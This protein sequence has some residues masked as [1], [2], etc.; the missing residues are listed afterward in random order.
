MYIMYIHAYVFFGSPFMRVYIGSFRSLCNACARA[1]VVRRVSMAAGPMSFGNAVD[2]Q[3]IGWGERHTQSLSCQ[4]N[5]KYRVS[6]S[7][8]LDCR[9]V[10]KRLS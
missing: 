2:G 7:Y 10:E 6:W 5:Y 8:I 1:I 9:K 3:R 4:R